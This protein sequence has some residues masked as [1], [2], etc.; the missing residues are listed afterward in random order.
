MTLDEAIRVL[1]QHNVTGTSVLRIT[2]GKALEKDLLAQVLDSCEQLISEKSGY[3]RLLKAAVE[4]LS[5]GGENNK[6]T[7]S[8]KTCTYN[9]IKGYGC[10]YFGEYH[11]RYAAEALALIGEDTNVPASADDTNVGGKIDSWISCKDKMPE[12]NTSVLFVYVSENGIKSVHYGYHQTVRGLG[13]S[14]GK[15]SGGWRYCND[16]VTHWM[17]IPEPPKE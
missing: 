8:C 1:R 14:W 12:D 7:K 10:R 11:W 5:C 4:D 16:D 6:C 9:S 15:I 13:S 3:K 2:K 17:P